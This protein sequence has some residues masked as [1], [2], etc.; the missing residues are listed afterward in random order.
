MS[1]NARI[2]NGKLIVEIDLN[3]KPYPESTSGK[4]LL[5]ASTRGNLA[6]DV[7][8]DGKPLTV[9]LNAYIKK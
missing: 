6:T 8:V 4:T 5:V 7:M 3:A 1:T 9:A 2:A